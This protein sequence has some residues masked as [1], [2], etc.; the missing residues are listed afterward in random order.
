MARCIEV[1]IADAI[2]SGFVEMGSIRVDRQ[3]ARQSAD[4]TLIDKTGTWLPA[5]N[6]EIF[7]RV[8]NPEAQTAKFNT[9]RFG[10][11]LFNG[12]WQNHMLFGGIVRSR[13]ISLLGAAK[14]NVGATSLFNGHTFNTARFNASSGYYYPRKIQVSCV[15]FSLYLDMRRPDTTYTSQTLKQIVDDINSNT[16]TGLGFTT[17]NVDTG[18]TIAKLDASGRA[19]TCRQVFDELTTI[20]GIPWRIDSSKQIFFRA[21]STAVPAPFSITDATIKPGQPESGKIQLRFTDEDYRNRQHVRL[22][23]GTVRTISDAAEITARGLIE[24]YEEGRG[25]TTNAGGDERATGLLRRFGHSRRSITIPTRVHRTEVGQT[26]SVAL[27]NLGFSGTMIIDRISAQI[28]PDGMRDGA[29][30]PN[31]VYTLSMSEFGDQPQD[32]VEYFRS[33]K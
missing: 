24:A 30:I 31:I 4:M 16:L 5:Q 27:Y 33:L 25:I 10:S 15:D 32:Y 2:L 23:N 28:G 18:P 1:V 20:T 9:H 12:T 29:L 14:I 3:G 17:T 13:E 21:P 19:K 8:V 6:A 26:V 22:E 11:T 7:I